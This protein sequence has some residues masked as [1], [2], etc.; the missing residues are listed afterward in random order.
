MYAQSLLGD[1]PASF[2]RRGVN[3][4]HSSRFAVGRSRHCRFPAA[5]NQLGIKIPGAR[6]S[7]ED[8]PLHRLHCLL[9][10]DAKGALIGNTMTLDH[11]TAQS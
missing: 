11:G 5:R 6:R 9:Y 2:N 10:R 8:L 4:G 7:A 1:I 3:R